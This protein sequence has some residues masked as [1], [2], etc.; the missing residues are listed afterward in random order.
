MR[1]NS[2]KNIFIIIVLII[3]LIVPSISMAIT[4]TDIITN[5]ESA[6]YGANPN[7]KV[8]NVINAVISLIQYVGSGISIIT[9]TWLGIRYMLASSNEKADLK[10]QGIPI[11][12]G[13]VLL[14]GAVN[15]VGIIADFGDGLN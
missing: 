11:V 4:E 12:I 3:V 5:M 1:K 10:K 14:F 9:V 15:L 13:C 7:G 6:K 8:G 2:F